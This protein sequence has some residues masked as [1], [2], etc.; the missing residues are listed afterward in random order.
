MNSFVS[1][2]RVRDMFSKA[3]S[4]MYRNEVPQYGTLLDLVM[5]VNAETLKKHPKLQ[6]ELEEADEFQRLDVERHGAIRLGT[7][8]ELATMRRI[9]EVMGMF[10]VGYYDLSVAGVPVHATAFRPT[11]DDA[12]RVN[13]FRVFTSLLR[14]ELISDLKLREQAKKILDARNIFTPRVLA[15]TEQFETVGGLTED[16]ATEFVAEATKIFRWQS[17][18]TVDMA[19]YQDLYQSHRLVADVVSFKGPHINHLTPRTLDIDAVQAQMASCGLV[20]KDVVE[21][22]PRRRCQILLRQ[23]SFKALEEPILFPG[24]TRSGSHAAR[25]GEIEQRGMAL[26]RKGRALYDRL[27]AHVRSMGDAGSTADNYEEKL[28]EIFVEFP[29]DIEKLFSEQLA[30]FRYF[31][32][33]ETAFKLKASGGDEFNLEDFRKEGIIDVHPITYEDFLPVSAAGIFQSNLGGDEQKNYEANDAKVEFELSLQSKV[34]DEF[35]LYER[36]QT[37]SMDWLKKCYAQSALN[38]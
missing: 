19:T 32:A 11:S 29:D 14:L 16:E 36:S 26:T 4:T 38:H 28:A 2:N 18:A 27:L 21:G 23:T 30:Y 35:D 5:K 1:S 8:H 15:L 34:F 17:Q 31:V 22:P 10:P 9:F 3:M 33:D 37:E 6:Q 7:P 20:A 13:P 24:N 25:F 12:L